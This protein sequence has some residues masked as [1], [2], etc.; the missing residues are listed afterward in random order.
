MGNKNHLMQSLTVYF[1]LLLHDG[2]NSPNHIATVLNK[3]TP[4]KALPA[5][6]TTQYFH[7]L[8]IE[9]AGTFTLNSIFFP[10]VF[11]YDL[12]QIMLVP[13]Q[14][15]TYAH[16]WQRVVRVESWV[17][18]HT[19]SLPQP[20]A[21]PVN[22]GRPKSLTA[23]FISQP[24][25]GPGNPWMDSLHTDLWQAIIQQLS[26]TVSWTDEWNQS[27]GHHWKTAYVFS[28]LLHHDTIRHQFRE[29]NQPQAGSSMQKELVPQPSQQVHPCQHQGSR[30][31]GRAGRREEG[32]Q[33][34][35]PGDRSLS[36]GFSCSIT[37]PTRVG[38]RRCSGC[39][40]LC[41]ALNS[42]SLWT[43][44]LN[45]KSC[46]L[47]LVCARELKAQLTIGLVVPVEGGM[48]RNSS[49]GLVSYT[50]SNTSAETITSVSQSVPG[51]Q[52]LVVFPQEALSVHA[53]P[54][55]TVGYIN[56]LEVTSYPHFTAENTSQHPTQDGST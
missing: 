19:G 37:S 7:R 36:G 27:F 43:N 1:S 48:V 15:I 21:P 23:M 8:D 28:L 25:W 34:L 52:H 22:T 9:W 47:H 18:G 42:H 17:Q 20:D 29:L 50:I 46:C 16:A 40:D 5:K 39:G 45:L 26:V 24:C 51:T 38:Q 33:E 32:K 3:N 41:K 30:K 53:M 13:D 6:E 12:K 31:V 55:Q 35:T 14:Q 10:A 2:N 49:G 54:E 11:L 4:K 56:Y 44:I